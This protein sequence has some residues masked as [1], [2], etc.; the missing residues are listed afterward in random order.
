MLRRCST[1]FSRRAVGWSIDRR[2]ETDLVNDALVDGR[3]RAHHTPTT[4]IHSDHG[5]QFTSWAF[6]ENLR[7]L[8]LLGSMGTVGDCY[9]NAPMESFWGSMQIELLNRQ[10]WT[11]RVELSTAMA[12]WIVNFYNPKR[13]TARSAASR[14]TSSKLLH[15]TPPTGPTLIR[16]VQRIGL[17]PSAFKGR[18]RTRKLHTAEWTVEQRTERASCCCLG[19]D[20]DR[21]QVVMA[22]DPRRI[23]Q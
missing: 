12:E 9:D 17:S 1:M 4:V 6:T 23:S 3:R 11:T 10:R 16:A 14:P 5:S 7:R 22:N 20:R 15:S 2:C 8:R 21:I 18:I 19:H 13:G